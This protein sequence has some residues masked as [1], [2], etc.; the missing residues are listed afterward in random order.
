MRIFAIVFAAALFASLCAAPAGAQTKQEQRLYNKIM[1]RGVTEQSATKNLAKLQNEALLT[2]IAIEHQYTGIQIAAVEKIHSREHLIGIAGRPIDRY[3]QINWII[4]ETAIKK[5]GN[6]EDLFQFFLKDPD[7]M[8]YYI[9]NTW[10]QHESPVSIPPDVTAR[11]VRQPGYDDYVKSFLIHQ[12]IDDQ[13]LLYE[14]LWDPAQEIVS[15]SAAVG[16]LTDQRLLAEVVKNHA[17]VAICRSAVMKITDQN[18][19][20]DIVKT[21]G[22]PIIKTLAIN[23]LTDQS[24]LL[25]LVTESG[26]QEIRREAFSKLDTASIQ[27]IAASRPRDEAMAVAAR[28]TARTSDWSA[29]INNSGQ[30]IDEVISAMALVPQAVKPTVSN[31]VDACHKYIRKGDEAKIPDLEFLLNSYGDMRLAE[32]YLNCGNQRL[33]DIGAAWAR[34]HGYNIGTGAGSH[35][36]TWGSQR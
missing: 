36:A 26:D 33:Y 21:H 24:L 1:R 6:E 11:L 31:I 27:T 28:V 16:E 35:R 32:D 34:R 2:R 23:R 18:V 13:E 5:I 8:A 15:R 3:G 20:A 9:T 12:Y 7:F 17:D 25:G 4:T 19:L 10:T 22:E 30:Q 29:E 14:I